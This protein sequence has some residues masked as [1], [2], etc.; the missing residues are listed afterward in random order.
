MVTHVYHCIF[1]WV[2]VFLTP[3]VPNADKKQQMQQQIKLIEHDRVAARTCDPCPADSYWE[4]RTSVGLNTLMLPF[5]KL[6][7]WLTH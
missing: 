6:V 7:S 3:V 4:H 5:C 2:L 1:M